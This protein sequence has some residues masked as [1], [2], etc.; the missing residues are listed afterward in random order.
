MAIRRLG[1]ACI[2]MTLGGD[3]VPKKQRITTNRTCRLATAQDKGIAHIASLVY[4]NITDLLSI[5]QWNES[6]GIRLFRMSSDMVPFLSHPDF[7]Y[8]IDDLDEYFP[9]SEALAAIGKFVADHDHRLSFTPDLSMF[10]PHPTTMLLTRLSVN[11]TL[12]P[13]FVTVWVFLLTTIARSTFTL[14]VLTVS[15]PRLLL[16]SVAILIVFLLLPL[17]A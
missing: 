3:S 8:T 12:L 9:V 7:S 14:A 15:Q 4:S 10:L 13:T 6:Q 1:Y 5:L 17:L 16:V 11:S 2:N